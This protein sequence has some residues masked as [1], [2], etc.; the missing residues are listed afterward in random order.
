MGCGASDTIID[1]AYCG[2]CGW[3]GLANQVAA[4]IRNKLP[5]A[6]IDCRP[7][8]GYTGQLVVS[9]I[10]KNNEKVKVYSG[11]KK[12]SIEQVNKIVDD[13]IAYY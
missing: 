13:T 3:S 9:L 7:E 6:V 12:T 4:A 8:D 2:G 5:K 1:I 10:L 11:D